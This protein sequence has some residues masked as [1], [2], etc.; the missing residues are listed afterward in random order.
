MTAGDA[1]AR[2]QE[3][4]DEDPSKTSPTYYPDSEVMVAL[5]EAQRFFVLLTLC[6]ETTLGWTIPATTTFYYMRAT[7]EDWLLPL[8]VTLPSGA[9]V[10]PARLA[11]LDA[12]DSGWQANIGAAGTTPARYCSLGF[13]FM[14]VYPQA[15]VGGVNVNVTYARAPLA[16]V[17]MTD[18][19]EIPEDYHP[20][21]CDYA[22][23][24][25][26]LKEGGQEL[27]KS[28]VYQERFMSEAARMAAFV[29]ERNL[30]L[31]YDNLP[32]ELRRL[33]RSKFTGVRMDL[34]G[35]GQGLGDRGQ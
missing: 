4:L 20:A 35:R 12:L 13:D 29:R 27:G 17:A 32:F 26:R 30:A 11:E 18:V 24:R 28:K 31:R 16:L 10:R 7:F 21:L 33:D 6:L 1:I 5:N 22:I 15:G 34:P 8:R 9:R 19:P 2:V 23:P 14:A 25:V 3:R